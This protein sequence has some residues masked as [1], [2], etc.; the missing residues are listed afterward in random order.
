[1]SLF[2]NP[3]RWARQAAGSTW[4]LVLMIVLH[5]IMCVFAMLLLLSPF[6]HAGPKYLSGV[7]SG[8]APLLYVGVLLPSMYLYAMSRLLKRID[9]LEK[10]QSPHTSPAESIICVLLKRIDDLE[11]RQS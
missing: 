7:L 8:A 4:R 9:G 1:M 2:R 6:R 10:R 11:K 5:F 3:E